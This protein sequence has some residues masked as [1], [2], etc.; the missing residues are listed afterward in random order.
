MAAKIERY[1]ATIAEMGHGWALHLTDACIGFDSAAK[2]R[3]HLEA[4]IEARRNAGVTTI[5]TLT[6]KPRTAIGTA[7]VKALS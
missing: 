3:Q 6:W 5:V 7:A 4:F 2:A 1:Q